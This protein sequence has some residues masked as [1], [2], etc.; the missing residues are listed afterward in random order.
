MTDESDF[1]PVVFAR[2]RAEAEDYKT[3]L[4]D[5]DIYVVIPDEEETDLIPIK[6]EENGIPILV[7]AEQLDEAEVV[8]EHRSD[9]DDDFNGDYDEDDEDDSHFDYD[10]ISHDENDLDDDEEDLL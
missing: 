2:N 5:H 1:V 8:I 3:L 9:L 4:E 10:S 6:T 7:S